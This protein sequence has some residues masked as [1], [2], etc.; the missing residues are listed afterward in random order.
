MVSTPIGRRSE[1]SHPKELWRDKIPGFNATLQ[2]LDIGEEIVY[3]LAPR[4]LDDSSIDRGVW[5]SETGMWRARVAMCQREGSWSE[6]RKM[7]IP[8]PSVFAF[9]CRHVIGRGPERILFKMK[10][11]PTDGSTVM[12]A[13]WGIGSGISADKAPSGDVHD[14][15]CRSWNENDGR[16]RVYE[17]LSDEDGYLFKM[18]SREMAKVWGASMQYLSVM[19]DGWI[20]FLE[21]A[22][23]CIHP[24]YTVFSDK[25]PFTE[26]TKEK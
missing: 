22:L 8:D 7:L 4:Q 26:I 14:E 13:R 6:R 17:S 5:M 25:R 18:S 9:H 12:I 11:F 1:L 2:H 19:S 10:G 23:A 24:I 16:V 15:A 3:P 21:N 20:R